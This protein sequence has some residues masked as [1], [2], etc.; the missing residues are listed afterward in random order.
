MK[1]YRFVISPR[2]T[3][4]PRSAGYLA[5]AHALGL[6]SVSGL[7]CHDLYFIE[8]APAAGELSQADLQRLAVE[9]LSDPVTQDYA[10]TCQTDQAV[11]SSAS[12]VVEVA[13]RPGVTDPVAEQIVRGARELGISGVERASTGLRFEIVVEGKN[14]EVHHGEHGE[15]REEENQEI[16]RGERREPETKK[17]KR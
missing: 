7:R 3:D 6:T 14:K 9:L 15:P 10:F 16:Y 12:S 13:L 1:N 11:S 5:D 4:D 8:G 17:N 2:R